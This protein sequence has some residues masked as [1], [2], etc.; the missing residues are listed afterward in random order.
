[1]TPEE[2]AQWKAEGESARWE[3]VSDEEAKAQG[4]FLAWTGSG[5]GGLF[6][7]AIGGRTI[8]GR[9]ELTAP[10]EFKFHE[11]YI[12]RRY[13]SSKAALE[14]MAMGLNWPL[15]WKMMEGLK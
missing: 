9:Y 7:E 10:N 6:I 12:S 15:L 13:E 2:Y 11:L 1:M 8:I 3:D 5:N 4:Q 14:R